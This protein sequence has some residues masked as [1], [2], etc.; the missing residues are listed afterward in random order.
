MS[1]ENACTAVVSLVLVALVGFLLVLAAG[2]IQLTVKYT[3]KR[4]TTPEGIGTVI[5]SG[6]EPIGPH[7]LTVRLDGDG[8]NRERRF[9]EQE[10]K[11]N[12]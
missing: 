10:V 1:I 5:L 2:N 9:V 8:D 4:V 6:W 11:I 3:G 12:D 7:R